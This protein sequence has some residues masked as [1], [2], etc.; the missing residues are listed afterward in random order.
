MIRCLDSWDHV[1]V[2]SWP[3]FEARHVLRT[4]TFRRYSDDSSAAQPSP[5][6]T[7][8]PGRDQE[9][10]VVPG[11]VGSALQRHLSDDPKMAGSRQPGRRLPLS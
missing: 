4:L 7:P 10:D 2:R 11:R 6:Y 5:Y 1:P 9:F 8:D 3:H